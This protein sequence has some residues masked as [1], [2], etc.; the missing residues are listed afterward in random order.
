MVIL[1]SIVAF[2]TTEMDDL[3]TLL[4]LFSQAK[5]SKE[6]VA[7]IIGK[8]L[9]L[10]LLI[11]GSACFSYYI[12]GIPSYWLG[13]LGIVPVIFG[14]KYIADSRKNARKESEGIAQKNNNGSFFLIVGLSFI[15]SLAAGGDNIAIYISF[16]TALSGI[17]ALIVSFI[18]F[19]IMQGIWFLL[20][21]LLM[22]FNGLKVFI[23]EGRRFII[24]VLF[25][26]L[27]IFIFIQNGT[28]QWLLGK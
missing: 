4:V 6:R 12:S 17:P 20:I 11:V 1:G 28:L 10:A 27:G 7:I 18:V 3:V 16:F 26:V 14:I 9:G 25:I 24:P 8:Y 21:W 23:T 2:I 13:F 19:A 15:M 5:S 22:N